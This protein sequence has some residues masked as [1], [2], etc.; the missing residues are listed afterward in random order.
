MVLTQLDILKV[1]WNLPGTDHLIELDGLS[2]SHISPF[3]TSPSEEYLEKYQYGPSAYLKEVIAGRLSD[4]EN[5]CS[6]ATG[7]FHFMCTS[8]LGL[9]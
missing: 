6:W 7:V 4:T 5:R 2:F 3:T 8:P 9:L 1:F